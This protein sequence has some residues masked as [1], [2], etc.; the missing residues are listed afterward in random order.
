MSRTLAFS[1]W[2]RAAGLASL[3]GL[4]L[5]MLGGCPLLDP[6]DSGTTK[7]VITTVVGN[8][9]AGD[10]GDGLPPLETSLYLVQDATVGPDGLLYFPDWN[11]HK[12]RRVK[13]GVVET[14]AGT[15]E[16][17]P[18]DDG[19]GLDVQFNHPTNIE[20]DSEGR[21]IIA[22]WHNSLVKRMDLTTGFAETIAGTGARSFSGDGGPGRQAALDLPSSVAYVPATGN[23]LISDQANFRIRVLEPNG[24]IY[25]LCGD[26]TPEYYGDGG[27]AEN[28]RLNAPKGQSAPPASRIT[29]N[30]QGEIIIADTGNNVI[31]MI[32]N[33]GFI[34]TIAG[35]GVAGYT[36]DGGPASAA[37]FNQP[38]DVAVGPDGSIYVADTYNHAVRVIKPDGTIDT[39]AGT[40]VRGFAGDGGPADQA[41]LD[42]PYGV[43]VGPD[44]TVYIADTHN[45]RIRR[46]TSTLPDDFDPNPV[47][48]VDAEI[49]PCTGQ[50]GSICTYIGT[51]Q[52][53]KNGDGHNRLETI[54]YWPI[55][56]EFAPN[57]RVILLDWNNHLVR[58]V[59]PD[60]T[61]RTIM[62]TDFVGDGPADLSDLT[63]AGAD[64]LTVDLNHPTDIQIMPNDDILIVA[65]HNHKLRVIDADNGRV[66]VLSGMG[67]GYVGD[68]V[69]NAFDARVNQPRSAVLTPDGNL[70]V[71]DQRN[72][73]IRVYKDFA[74][75]RENSEVD[76]VIGTGVK[77]FNGDGLAGLQTQLSFATGGNPEPSGGIT[78]DPATGYLYISDSQNEVIR[79]VEFHNGD[80]YDST[81]TIIAGTP[82]EVGYEGDGGPAT[83]A[84]LSNPQDLEIGPDGN[85]YFADTDNNVIRRVNLTTGVIDTI[86]GTGVN[87]YSGDGGPALQAQLSRP[88]GV[89]FGP[90]GNLYISDTFN[91]RV[92]K[93]EMV[94]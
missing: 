69:G 59:L 84:K 14:I 33:A 89:A 90:D 68:G 47:E 81:V 5:A 10:N 21:M 16:L 15:G 72:Q 13:D 8:G 86:A 79:R 60:D 56:M 43:G 85:L 1:S 70:F 65:W 75:Q 74:D 48:D 3:G 35:T 92:R 2:H 36:G 28:A 22:A 42:R 26:G 30:P 51:G 4:T 12:I 7:P 17:G 76:T 39:F 63:M 25:T 37:T 23:I 88:F 41:Q 34:H 78:Y 83:A 18:A 87:G 73:R 71:V 66:R 55:D 31:R 20:F 54:L 32:D 24:T 19:Y 40:G 11:N 64:P 50:P 94:Y 80:L 29:L 52:K 91:S 46:V 62:G 44:G 9:V 6:K 53:G 61:I 67:A 45:H 82:G 57:G 58:E 38:S 49:I 27:R 77:G 93:V